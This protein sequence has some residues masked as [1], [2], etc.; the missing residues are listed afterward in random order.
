MLGKIANR[1]LEEIGNWGNTVLL[2]KAHLLF[3]RYMNLELKIAKKY[4]SK[5]FILLRECQMKGRFYL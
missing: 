1:L 5:I 2:L 4:I 3:H